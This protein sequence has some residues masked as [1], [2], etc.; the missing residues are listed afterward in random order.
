MPP[1][2]ALEERNG[3]FDIVSRLAT[4]EAIAD[5]NLLS[6]AKAIIRKSCGGEMPQFWDL[7]SGR[8]SIPLEA[9]RLG[10]QVTGSDLNPVSVLIGKVLLDFPQ[11]FNGQAAVNSTS[12]RVAA[13]QNMEGYRWVSRRCALL[14]EM[15]SR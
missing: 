1:E 4:W 3:F 9:Q 5:E 12:R 13:A 14:R 6:E 11:R 2:R 10:L 15:A 8:A 7:F